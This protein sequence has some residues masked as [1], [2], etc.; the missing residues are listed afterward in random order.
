MSLAFDLSQPPL[1]VN[2][3]PV[4]ALNVPRRLTF[5]AAAEPLSVSRTRYTSAPWHAHKPPLRVDVDAAS[6]RPRVR[7]LPQIPVSP[8][9]KSAPAGP[10]RQ[11]SHNSLRP[12]PSVPELRPTPPCPPAAVMFSVIPATPIP[13]PTPITTPR[14]DPDANLGASTSTLLVPAREI[15]LPPRFASLSLRLDTSPDALQPAMHEIHQSSKPLPVVP[16]SPV[17]TCSIIMEPPTPTT[18]HRKRVSKLRR[19]LGESIQLE[20]FPP[21]AKGVVTP[22]TTDVYAQTVVAVKRL[23]D[24]DSCE[25]SGDSSDDNDDDDVD[26]SEVSSRFSLVLTHGAVHRT[27]PVKRFSRKWVREK[28]GERWIE[29]NYSKILNDLR[30]L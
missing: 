6:A 4:R 19:H 25:D 30:S 13:P 20:L 3:P 2:L 24:I 7:P 1:Q 9:P 23:L 14:P 10:R 12:L 27:V 18:A 8:A 15:S 29:E 11:M 17:S 21:D 28:G 5:P 16:A 22:C 26:G